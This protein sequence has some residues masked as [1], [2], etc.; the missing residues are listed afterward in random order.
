VTQKLI[1]YPSILAV[2]DAGLR[3]RRLNLSRSLTNL[4]PI[5]DDKGFDRSGTGFEMRSG[6]ASQVFGG[7]HGYRLTLGHFTET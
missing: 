3:A 4:T 2:R 7:F 5:T 6:P 1:R